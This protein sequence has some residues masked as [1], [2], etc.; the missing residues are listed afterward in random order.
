PHFHLPLPPSR[1]CVSVPGLPQGRNIMLSASLDVDTNS[2]RK[3]LHVQSRSYWAPANIGPYSQAV[4]NS[5]WWEVA[6]QIPLVPASM[7]LV[8]GHREQAVLALQH[9]ERIWTAVGA[10]GKAAVAWVVS[11]AMVGVVVNTWRREAL[12]IIV[13]AAALPRGAEVEWV[14][15]GVDNQREEGV[16]EMMF[17]DCSTV[18]EAADKFASKVVAADAVVTVYL[19]VCVGSVQTFLKCWKGDVAVGVVPVDAVW[20]GDGKRRTIGC[21]VKRS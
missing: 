13:Q 15:F 14:G 8:E 10:I 5:G 3:G 6:G 4:L 19:P 11:E 1:V 12:V 17:A 18:E 7:Q 16:M 9:L 20:D 21:V 2:A